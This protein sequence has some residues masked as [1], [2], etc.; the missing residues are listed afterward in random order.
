MSLSVLGRGLILLAL[1]CC[2]IGSVMGITAGVRR[3]ISGGRQA[4]WMAFAFSACTLAAVGVSMDR[5][6]PIRQQQAG[7]GDPE[8]T[9]R[10]VNAH[11]AGVICL[12]DVPA[13]RSSN[14]LEE[15]RMTRMREEDD[16]D[17]VPMDARS[18]QGAGDQGYQRIQLLWQQERR[19]RDVHR[20][21]PRP[22]VASNHGG[23]S[24][25]CPLGRLQ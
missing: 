6:R 3:S 18:V 25:L 15:P 21:A 7:E 12:G 13:E 9:I 2:A 8:C 19:A 24:G 20:G 14:R 11:P 17:R 1:A 4:R 23:S 10:R 16:A 5:Q 22:E